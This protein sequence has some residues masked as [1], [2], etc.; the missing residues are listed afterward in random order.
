MRWD[1]GSVQAKRPVARDRSATD[2]TKCMST[3]A[4]YGCTERETWV[5][6][7][8]KGDAHSTSSWVAESGSSWATRFDSWVAFRWGKAEWRMEGIES[9]GT[10]S[11]SEKA[12]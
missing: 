6:M 9:N 3:N 2:D 10:A 7:L 5:V 8:L 11:C 1:T 12:D 4:P